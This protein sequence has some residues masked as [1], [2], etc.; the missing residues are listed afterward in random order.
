[1][2][3]L[4]LFPGGDLWGQVFEKE[5]NDRGMACTVVRGPDPIYGSKIQDWHVPPGVFDGVIG[6]PPCQTFSNAN[7]GQEIGVNLIPEY[8]RIV[9]EANP[10]WAIMENVLPARP[11]GP[12]WPV[13]KV[14]DWD[15]GGWTHRTRLFWWFGL[16]TPAQPEIRLGTPAYSVVATSW[17]DRGKNQNGNLPKYNAEVAASLQ[18]MPGFDTTVAK[19]LPSGMTKKQKEMFI[20]QLLGNG[21]PAAMGRWTAKHVFFYLAYQGVN[22]GINFS[23]LGLYA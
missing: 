16:P 2:L 9:E 8:L 4:S 3:V 11:Y 6:G 10:K 20:I 23:Q 1:M 12:D 14:R 5:M 22:H 17:K 7:R 21:L 13:T 18:G 15:V 19:A